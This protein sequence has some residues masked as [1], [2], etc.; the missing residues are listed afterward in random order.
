MVY[1]MHPITYFTSANDDFWL[2][3]QGKELFGCSAD[4]YNIKLINQW[5]AYKD[6]WNSLHSAKPEWFN[7]ELNYQFWS[8]RQH[9]WP[10]LVPALCGTATGLLHPYQLSEHS[11]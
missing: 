8:S 7:E 2:S 6:E 1:M 11:H 10:D 9:K 3:P 4:E 5:F